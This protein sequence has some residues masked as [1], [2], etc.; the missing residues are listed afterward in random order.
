MNSG[1]YNVLS[2][3]E[4][5][6]ANGGRRFWGAES[7]NGDWKSIAGNYSQR[8]VTTTTYRLWFETGSSKST[9]S[10]AIDS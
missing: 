2:A 3:E 8:K 7:S 10:D 4:M 5:S 9:Q 6:L 1:K